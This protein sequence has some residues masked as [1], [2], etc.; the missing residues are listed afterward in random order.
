MVLARAIGGIDIDGDFVTDL[1]PS[2]IFYFGTSTGAQQ[3]FLLTATDPPSP[4]PF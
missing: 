4:R 2:R 1:D 3:G